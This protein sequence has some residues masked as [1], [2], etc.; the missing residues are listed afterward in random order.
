MLHDGAHQG[1]LGF[2]WP[3]AI[4]GSVGRSHLSQS[5]F[6]DPQ[7]SELKRSDSGRSVKSRYTVERCV[8]TL[9]TI[10]CKPLQ[11]QWVMRMYRKRLRSAR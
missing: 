10:E 7:T 9:D 11:P 2:A 1:A 6:T 3:V 8:T 4:L 5:D